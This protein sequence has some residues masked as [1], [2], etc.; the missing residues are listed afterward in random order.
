M[1]IKVITL[2]QG[3]AFS[4]TKSYLKG[5][6]P[7]TPSRTLRLTGERNNDAECS[8]RADQSLPRSSNPNLFGGAGD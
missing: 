7:V 4:I 8:V 5:G 2:T 6:N 3:H 1:D